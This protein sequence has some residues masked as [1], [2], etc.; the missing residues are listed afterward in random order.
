M[1]RF[2]FDARISP[3]LL[4][5]TVW[6]T[7]ILDTQR[8]AED[9]HEIFASTLHHTFNDE[10]EGEEARGGSRIRL[11][12]E[13][14]FARRRWQRAA[15]VLELYRLRFGH[16]APEGIWDFGI[17]RDE[18]QQERQRVQ[19][20]DADRMSAHPEEAYRRGEEAEIRS[21][22]LRR[23]SVISFESRA[24]QQVFIKTL[25]GKVFMMQVTASVSVEN[26]KAKIQDYEGIP[27]D[28]Q[29]LIHAGRQLADGRTLGS[30]NIENNGT[31]HIVLDLRGC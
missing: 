9:C 3:P 21:L 6:H 11:M 24:L 25:T 10:A 19:L 7:H 26:L 13:Q 20:S 4:L 8:Y 14:T 22:G 30:Y 16:E 1:L 12:G 18:I 5:D 29:R 31:I 23:N 15:L 2:L 27:P 17:P 28:M